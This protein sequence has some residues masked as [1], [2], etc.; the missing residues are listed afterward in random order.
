[1]MAGL[2]FDTDFQRAT[3]HFQ[4]FDR[5]GKRSEER[6]PAPRSRKVCVWKGDPAIQRHFDPQ[7]TLGVRSEIDDRNGKDDQLVQLSRLISALANAQQI[8][9]RVDDPVV[10]GSIL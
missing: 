7:L 6:C 8:V 9:A 2:S 10:P 1:M 5:Q 4:V 3:T